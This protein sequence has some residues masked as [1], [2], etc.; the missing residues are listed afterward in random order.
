MT[1]VSPLKAS[2]VRYLVRLSGTVLV[3]VGVLILIRTLARTDPWVAPPSGVVFYSVVDCLRQ[4]YP[5]K[6]GEVNTDLD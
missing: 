5:H 1:P 3:G 6:I 4:S 2:F